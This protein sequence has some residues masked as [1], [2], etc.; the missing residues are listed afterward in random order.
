M[1]V[2]TAQ[3]PFHPSPLTVERRFRGSVFDVADARRFARVTAGW[4]GVEAEP[5]EHV[6]EELARRAVCSERPGFRVSLTLDGSDVR[7]CV[8][9][10]ASDAAAPGGAAR[11]RS[12]RPRGSMP[13]R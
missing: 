9:E 2:D 6:V 7:V 3:P 10:D 11:I 12:L 1:T 5:V 8:E 4:W 13:R